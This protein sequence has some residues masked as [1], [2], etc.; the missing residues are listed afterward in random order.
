VL[1]LQ[2]TLSLRVK[3]YA[4]NHTIASFWTM[5]LYT[6]I[7]IYKYKNSIHIDFK[8][9]DA[10]AEFVAVYLVKLGMSYKI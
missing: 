1:N 3:E 7:S 2:I 4:M 6:Y 8:Y 9:S 10:Q 5:L